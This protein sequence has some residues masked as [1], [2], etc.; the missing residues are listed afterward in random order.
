MAV[1]AR[2]EAFYKYGIAVT[3][4]GQH[5]VLV[6]AAGACGE[7]AHAV[8]LEFADGFGAMWSSCVVVDGGGS[9]VGW[10]GEWGLGF[11]ERM[12]LR[13][14]ERWPFMVSVLLGQYFDMLA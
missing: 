4:I 2:L 9:G 1:V 10:A 11:V 5:D 7:A 6:A 8:C 12:P 13:V 3:V 14:K